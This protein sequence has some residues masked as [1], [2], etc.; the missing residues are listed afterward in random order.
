MSQ[1][2]EN[3]LKAATLLESDELVGIPTETVYGLAANA[4]SDSA[5]IKIFEAKN[6]P[7]F[8]P[9]IV[10]VVDIHAINKYAELDPI[11][12]KLAEAFMPGPFTL[13]LKKKPIISDLVT[14]GSAKVAIRVPNQMMTTKLLMLLTFPLAAPSANPSGYVSPT[15]ALHVL[16]GLKNKV[17]YILDG[18]PSDV[19]LES[20]I[21]EVSNNQIILHR[22]G[23]ITAEQMQAVTGLKVKE[24][25]TSNKLAS[26]G[27][28]KSHY[29]TKTPLYRGDIPEM[30]KEYADKNIA[31][32]SFNKLY[33]GLK[34]G[35]QYVLSPNG[36]LNEAARH[37]FEVM[38]C[39][40]EFHFDIIL[41]DLFPDEGLGRAINDRLGRAQEINK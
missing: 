15:T 7:T 27:Q 11:S 29:A 28:M 36:D 21:A 40:D 1:I 37:L 23:A 14:A 9:L 4:L 2:G 38:R 41:T 24:N 31:I 30:I 35:H 3:L 6:R 12:L 32:I 8:N 26:S 22:T 19:G 34:T 18:G 25:E 5:V 10:H 13:L 17:P 33:E 16:E 20:T 39:I